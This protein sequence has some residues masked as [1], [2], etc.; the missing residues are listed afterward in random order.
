MRQSF[1]FRFAS[2]RVVAVRELGRAAA[3]L[4]AVEAAAVVSVQSEE[5]IA[6]AMR[7]AAQAV[8]QHVAHA[9]HVVDAARAVLVD[10][11]E[12]IVDDVRLHLELTGG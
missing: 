7:G 11:V 1:V 9:L 8:T 4:V 10:L 12:E 5:E 6:H 3:S 2:G